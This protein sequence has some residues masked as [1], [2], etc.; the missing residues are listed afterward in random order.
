MQGKKRGRVGKAEITGIGIVGWPASGHPFGVKKS[1]QTN[2]KEKD[3]MSFM[4]KL[5]MAFQM[6]AE[7]EDL[8]DQVD[9]AAAES[10]D[11]AAD[12]AANVESVVKSAV[13]PFTAQLDE[14]KKQHVDQSAK[15]TE[16]ET[17][18]SKSLELLTE[19][20]KSLDANQAQK[21]I[22]D[23]T[24]KINVIEASVSKMAN[25]VPSGQDLGSENS[26]EADQDTSIYKGSVFEV[27]ARKLKGR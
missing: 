13:E 14:I 3:D 2:N 8:D 4:K 7:S 20:C 10:Q 16:L 6:A 27:M 18:V 24:K 21:S 17:A 11:E 15:V 19:I 23:L 26:E 5:A 1:L 9:S 22:D 25:H 12:E